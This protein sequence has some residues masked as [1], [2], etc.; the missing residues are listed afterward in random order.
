[1]ENQTDL[2]KY[3]AVVRKWWWLMVACALV[4]GVSS[5]LGTRQM[6]RLYQS[7]ITVMIGRGLEKANP[8]YQELFMGERLAQTY[9]EMVKRRP[10]LAGAAQALGLRYIPSAGM[11]STRPVAGT[12]LLEIS[13]R[14]TD[15]ERAQALANEIAHQLILQTPSGNPEQEDRRQFV[16]QQLEELEAKIQTAR[17]EIE[18]EQ[19]KLASANSARAIQ[20]YEANIRALEQKLT[21]YQSTY[22]SLLANFEN[23][24]NTISIIEPATLP[25]WPISPN[26]QQTVM[27]ATAIGLGLALA[28][29]FLIEFLDDTVRSPEEAARVTGLPAIAEIPRLKGEGDGYE[30]MLITALDPVSPLAE[31]YRRLRTNVRLSAIDRGLRTLMVTSA[32]PSEGKSVTLANLAIVFAQSGVKVLLMDTDLRRPVQHQIFGAPNDRGLSDAVLDLDHNVMDY[33]QPTEVDNLY[34]LP[35]GELPPNAP[36]LLASDRLGELVE[37]ALNTVDL[38]LFDSAPCLLA[39]DAI[40][41]GSRVDG[42]LLVADIGQSRRGMLSKTVEDLRKANLP[43]L[44]VV[45]NRVPMK[46]SSYYHY[47]Y[48]YY[49]SY[50]EDDSRNGHH[51]KAQ[52]AKEGL[53]ARMRAGNK[54]ESRR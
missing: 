11:I 22:A 14:D 24:A 52:P 25:Y 33:A 39:A 12:Q 26:V 16:R 23:S 42:V 6:P 51:A 36:E 48:G 3:L 30:G 43:L 15:P 8:S 4:A 13:V 21:S 18:A 45:A 1:M 10:I 34:L 5:Y 32:S 49:Y 31:A 47:K 28:G 9:A 37:E 38:V 7:T 29:A 46:T 50:G 41:L 27:L 17:D 19:E 44:G 54:G 40:V 2:G 35:T 53:L 20:Q